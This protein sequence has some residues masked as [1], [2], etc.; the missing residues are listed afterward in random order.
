MERCGC[1][2]HSRRVPIGRLFKAWEAYYPNL[3]CIHIFF[4]GLPLRLSLQI[5]CPASGQLHQKNFLTLHL[6]SLNLTRS[7]WIRVLKLLL[8]QP[9][10]DKS[11]KSRKRV[12]ILMQFAKPWKH[13]ML[14]CSPSVRAITKLSAPRLKKLKVVVKRRLQRVDNLKPMSSVLRTRSSIIASHTS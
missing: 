3:D 7:L 9:K 1:L 2:E 13:I 6:A 12:S 10:S 4:R 11:T 5:A 14:S 8:W